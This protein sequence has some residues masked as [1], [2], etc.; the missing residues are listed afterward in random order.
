MKQV[1]RLCGYTFAVLLGVCS[2]ETPLEDAQLYTIR[3]DDAYYRYDTGWN[4]T[5]VRNN[6][7]RAWRTIKTDWRATSVKGIEWMESVTFRASPPWV[8]EDRRNPYHEIVVSF[9]N[10]SQRRITFAGILTTN[11]RNSKFVDQNQPGFFMR[12]LYP[13]QEDS[14]SEK[15]FRYR[16]QR[17]A[18]APEIYLVD[19]AEV[20]S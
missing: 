13:G 14:F 18:S 8:V 12:S 1:F 17:S 19:M 6:P 5:R 10:V 3:Y 2:C 11:S 20:E 9:R 7:S 4:E 16:D 15:H